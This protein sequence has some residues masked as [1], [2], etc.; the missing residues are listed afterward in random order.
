MRR[1]ALKQLPSDGPAKSLLEVAGEQ[2]LAQI[3]TLLLGALRNEPEMSVR[4]KVADT[5]SQI[6]DFLLTKKGKFITYH[7]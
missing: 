7:S 6:A 3:Q 1:Y 4:V 5:A 2:C